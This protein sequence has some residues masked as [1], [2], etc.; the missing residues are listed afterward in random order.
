MSGCSL[1]WMPRLSVI[2]IC[3]THCPPVDNSSIWHRRFFSLCTVPAKPINPRVSSV[4][5]L[6]I[7]VVWKSPPVTVTNITDTST[8]NYYVSY[9]N[10]ESKTTRQIRSSTEQAS[11]NLK[12]NTRYEI[13]VKSFKV[14]NS[15]VAGSWSDSLKIKT[16]ESGKSCT[17]NHLSSDQYSKQYVPRSRLPLLFMCEVL[18]T[19]LTKSA[20]KSRKLNHVTRSQ[21]DTVSVWGRVWLANWLESFLPHF[22]IKLINNR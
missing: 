8:L 19:Q 20:G 9:K 21:T 14:F 11:F 13:K 2:P 12:A 5:H 4:N 18:S 10:R 6:S 22:L 7:T 15:S 17:R 16:N 3:Q 1:L